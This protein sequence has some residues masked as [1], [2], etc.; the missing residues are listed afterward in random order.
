MRF[1]GL[2]WVPDRTARE[3]GRIDVLCPVVRF[4]QFGVDIGTSPYRLWVG[5][6]RA[7]VVIDELSDLDDRRGGSIHR[8]PS[9]ALRSASCRVSI[10]RPGVSGLHPGRQFTRVRTAGTE[11]DRQASRAE[12]HRRGDSAA[13][14]DGFVV[15]GCSSR[16]ARS[17]PPT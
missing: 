16:R 8:C 6:M 11:P 14:R 9:L 12:R 7:P 1:V 4:H 5:Q 15:T 10:Q 2:R 17:G 3:G 13:G